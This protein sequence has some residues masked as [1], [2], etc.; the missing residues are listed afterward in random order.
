[1]SLINDTFVIN[2]IRIPAYDKGAFEIGDIV[3]KVDGR[4]IHQLA[5]SLKEFV[6]GGN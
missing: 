1:M 2:Q 3:L 5:D 4:D 6:C